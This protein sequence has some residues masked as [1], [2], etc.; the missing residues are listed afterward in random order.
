MAGEAGSAQQGGGLWIAAAE[1]AVENGG[2]F[3]ISFFK[4]LRSEF[5]SGLPV[6]D[7]VLLEE[8]KCVCFKN[9]SPFVGVIPSGISSAEDM[10][11]ARAESAS[12]DIGHHVALFLQAVF[13]YFQVF[14]SFYHGNPFLW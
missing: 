14:R 4:N 7:T 1:V 8:F 5:L 3:L 12:L 11:E 9:F 6:K 13:K 10:G 2:V